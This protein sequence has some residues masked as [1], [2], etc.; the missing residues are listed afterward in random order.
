MPKAQ[1]LHERQGVI[2][3]DTQAV[4]QLGKVVHVQVCVHVR[5][6]AVL[7]TDEGGHVKKPEKRRTRGAGPHADQAEAELQRRAYGAGRHSD[8][9]M[10]SSSTGRRGWSTVRVVAP[11]GVAT[12]NEGSGRAAVANE[13]RSE[14][15]SLSV[16]L[17]ATRTP[18]PW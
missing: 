10:D 17:D 18:L 11:E 7:H 15:T 6:L 13:T 1:Q 14:K 8:W 5:V 3:S 9:L 2:Q 4:H 16:A 12:T